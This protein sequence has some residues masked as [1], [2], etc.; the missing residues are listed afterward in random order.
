MRYRDREEATAEA[1]ARLP[2][3]RLAEQ[4]GVSTK[5][6]GKSIKVCPF[7]K[8]PK[9][10]DSSGF[11]ER[12]GQWFFKCHNTSCPTGT[13]TLNEVTFLAHMTGRSNS[14]CWWDWLKAA[15][16]DIE[17]VRRDLR[18]SAKPVLQQPKPE[19]PTPPPPPQPPPSANWE[20]DPDQAA[21]T[22]PSTGPDTPQPDD[23]QGASPTNPSP[24]ELAPAPADDLGPVSPVEEAL[25][26]SPPDGQGE[27]DG[28]EAAAASTAIAHGPS[29]DGP[30][31]PPGAPLRNDSHVAAIR[32]FYERCATLP[33]QELDGLW[34]KRGLLPETAE[35]FGL[36][37][38]HRTNAEVIEGM[39]Q[40]FT[41][42]AMRLAGL[43]VPDRRRGGDAVKPN[44][45]L[46][47]WGP[48]GRKVSAPPTKGDGD[49]TGSD[50]ERDEW[51][52]TNPILIPFFNER[53]Q[54]VGLRC[55]KRSLPGATPVLYVAQPSA[56]W[57]QAHPSP[58]AQDIEWVVVCESEFKAMAVQQTLGRRVAACGLC[59]ISMAK[60]WFVVNGLAEWIE[61]L[62]L[63]HGA[64]VVV[65]YD[66]ED[67]ATP[68]LPGYQ[69]NEKRR[70]DSEVW[71]RYLAELL[72]RM[73]HEAVV[74]RLPS[75]WRENGK[76]D[77][78]GAL[79]R[80][81][82]E[83]SPPTPLPTD[84]PAVR[85]RIAQAFGQV[86]RQAQAVKD[87]A[88]V[89]DAR[90]EWVVSKELARI[91]YTPKVAQGSTYSD[92]EEQ[93]N[94]MR[95]R[96]AA[97]EL[98]RRMKKRDSGAA[99]AESEACAFG[100]AGQAVMAMWLEFANL[101]EDMMGRMYTL[102]PLRA[103][104]RGKDGDDGGHNQ[105]NW[106]YR[107]LLARAAGD[108]EF[109]WACALVLKG[110]PVPASD[111][112]LRPLFALRRHSGDLERMVE[113]RNIHAPDRRKGWRSGLVS[114]PSEAWISTEKLRRFLG[115]LGH[116]AWLE[117][118]APL[119]MLQEDVN[120]ALTGH[121]VTEVAWHGWHEASGLWFCADAAFP[122]DGTWVAPNDF[123]VFWHGSGNGW[124]LARDEQ[125][126]FVD[127]D[128]PKAERLL[129]GGCRMRPDQVVVRHPTGKGEFQLETLPEGQT[130][131]EG[132]SVEVLR[133]LYG[134]LLRR[135]NETLPM[136][137]GTLAVAMTLMS[138]AGP[139]VYARHNKISG[140]VLNGEH[141]HGKS[142]VALWLMHLWGYQIASG[143]NLRMTSTAG[144][145]IVGQQYSFQPF[146]LE[147][148]QADQATEVEEYLKAAFDHSGGSKKG[149]SRTTR[150][151]PLVCGQVGFRK[152]AARERFVQLHVHSSQR[153][154]LADGTQ[155]NHYEWFLNHKGLLFTLVRHI[156][157][158]RKKFAAMFQAALQEW[159]NDA[160]MSRLKD[161]PRFVFGS[162]WAAT[163]A[164][165]GLLEMP[166][167]DDADYALHLTRCCLQ[168]VGSTAALTE[169]DSFLADVLVA[170]QRGLFGE[171]P[172][173]LAK[174]F[175]AELVCPTAGAPPDA[176]NQGM[177]WHWRLYL[178]HKVVL[179]VVRQDLRKG[180][181]EMPLD[182]NDV[183]NQLGQRPCWV[184]LRKPV[185]FSGTQ[186]MNRAW[187]LDLDHLP[188]L[189][190]CPCPDEE[191]TA[192]WK[193]WTETKAQD[194]LINPTYWWPDPRR[195]GFFEIIRRLA[196][197]C[198]MRTS[199]SGETVMS[200]GN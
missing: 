68:G 29:E 131:A 148:F 178:V 159:M 21:N 100:P 97:S 14:E 190:Y 15:G 177:W 196:P 43:L 126:E 22:L 139:E 35:R 88:K 180:G 101:Y 18:E 169:V 146:W 104:Q 173:D 67:K 113:L 149:A 170:A 9:H 30:P 7:C 96:R 108:T 80:L 114:L 26:P 118:A 11:F 124:R 105:G 156:L 98:R 193:A 116:C 198:V 6:D 185:Y 40:E 155:A 34:Q 195:G 61:S 27:V 63:A 162:G 50:R 191:V 99:L 140:L 92:G 117:G 33:D 145:H 16:L 137:D 102:K 3:I 28:E 39:R 141:G 52:E 60:N 24:Q 82:W 161:R 89:T 165:E 85:P 192:A 171:E 158:H 143:V 48:T 23:P 19:R 187:C 77:W 73:S 76:A 123:G 2:L 87:L 154:I 13:K 181:E 150:G 182:G 109:A 56:A 179:R 86:L 64:K 176:P 4:Y 163:K 81:I 112:V 184:P 121:D 65:V 106:R 151:V 136:H 129:L 127:C 37:W 95:L 70:H 62:P 152:P 94:A 135:L 51:A 134:E 174:V 79:A 8:D 200:N 36:R 66:N 188:G 157:L 49:G 12:Q 90:T 55:H 166:E 183:Q 10:K 144:M 142:T 168:A 71:A 69:S 197:E 57:R 175:K 25:P 172:E 72:E 189:G 122:G 133:E 84:W 167:P 107:Y 110:T 199:P 31:Q 59:G 47:G 20:A 103:E 128:V 46:C 164:I 160:S 153:A 44:P 78:D 74:G 53:G 32:T 91:S 132:Q 186:T 120:H 1:R 42:T 130:F 194:A 147:E 58:P 138:A 17:E 45:Q 115:R 111:F 125:G 41:T 75:A 54:L 119:Q 38:S 5:G 83:Y 93:R